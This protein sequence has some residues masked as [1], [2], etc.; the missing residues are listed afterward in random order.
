MPLPSRVECRYFMSLSNK[1]VFFGCRILLHVILKHSTLSDWGYSQCLAWI[2]NK[3]K[4][5]LRFMSIFQTDRNWVLC[6]STGQVCV[7]MF[8]SS[9]INLTF[10]MESS[11]EIIN[12]RLLIWVCLFAKQKTVIFNIYPCFQKDNLAMRML[13]W[14][15]ENL[16]LAQ[17]WTS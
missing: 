13:I 1:A 11:I 6:N 2:L 3:V 12:T 10:F 16:F 5:N 17:P 4:W 8:Y 15:S 9:L 7:K 14:V